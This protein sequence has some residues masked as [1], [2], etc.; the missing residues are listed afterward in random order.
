MLVL[1]KINASRITKIC[2]SDDTDDWKGQ[3]IALI[4][5]WTQF[6]GQDVPCVRVKLEKPKKAKKAPQRA[7]QP[8]PDALDDDI[9]FY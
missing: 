6:Q 5:D 2:E 1:N 8:D 4:H 3:Q 7:S 9:P